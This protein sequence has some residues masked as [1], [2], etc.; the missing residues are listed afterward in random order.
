MSTFEKLV[1]V[2]GIFSSLAAVYIAYVAFRTYRDLSPAAQLRRRQAEHM[3]HLAALVMQM[4][5]RLITVRTSHR[6][7]TPVAPYL[8]PAFCY[9][10]RQLDKLLDK[11]SRLGLIVVC[12]GDRSRQTIGMN[13]WAM[14]TTL[15]T[16]IIELSEADTSEINRYDPEDIAHLDANAQ[17]EERAAIWRLQ[18]PFLKRNLLLGM[19][20]LGDACIAY[21]NAEPRRRWSLVLVFRRIGLLKRTGGKR[22]VI[23]KDLRMAVEELARIE[24]PILKPEEAEGWD[25]NQFRDYCSN[26]FPPMI[27][28]DK[29]NADYWTL[30]PR[31]PW[32]LRDWLMRVRPRQQRRSD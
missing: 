30:E 9:D 21:E 2:A 27:D 14:N 18:W 4:L 10:A 6:R 20:R 23:W 13:R 8:F 3:D 25:H 19:I 11:C 32:P 29:E 31:D 1:G 17:K 22:V 5:D 7:R 15:R 28:K 16:S 12:L 24:L 26:C